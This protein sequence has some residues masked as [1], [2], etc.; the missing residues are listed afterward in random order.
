VGIHRG[1]Y[2]GELGL[3]HRSKSPKLLIASDSPLMVLIKSLSSVEVRVW[4]F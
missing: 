4:E 1:K 2:L 3:T